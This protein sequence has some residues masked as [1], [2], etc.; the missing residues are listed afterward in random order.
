[1]KV[2]TSYDKKSLKNYSFHKTAAKDTKVSMH[3]NSKH[4]PLWQVS[5]P[6]TPRPT[7]NSE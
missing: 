2:T 5:D 4:E 3:D 1:M 6:H 7:D